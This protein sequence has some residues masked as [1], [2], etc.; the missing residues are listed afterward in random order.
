MFFPRRLLYPSLRFV[1][2]FLPLL[3]PASCFKPTYMVVKSPFRVTNASLG[4][5]KAQPVVFRGRRL[6]KVNSFQATVPHERKE[7]I[8]KKW[9]LQVAEG[10]PGS[11]RS[12]AESKRDA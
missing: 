8:V 1:A 9:K 7:L 10:D 2:S 3:L 4:T 5:H 12:D 6:L 11:I